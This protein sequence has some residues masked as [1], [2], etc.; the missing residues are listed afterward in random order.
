M[1]GL[2]I[3]FENFFLNER[4]MKIYPNPVLE[5]IKLFYESIQFYLPELSQVCTND[6]EKRAN[7]ILKDLYFN[8]MDIKQY[9]DKIIALK[10][11]NSN[12]DQ[13]IL[14]CIIINLIDEFRFYH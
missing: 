13:E 10:K 4:F 7:S 11:S 2:A 1:N 5:K 8:K 6:T 14:S 12:R 9:V 3:M